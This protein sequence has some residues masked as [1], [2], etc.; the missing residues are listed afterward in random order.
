M[1]RIITKIDRIDRPRGRIRTAA[2][3]RVSSD[4]D[5][6]LV[7]LGN[8]RI[9]YETIIS[10]NPAWEFAGIYY[11]EGLSGTSK[12]AR[13][14]LMR[15]VSDCLAGR[16][17]QVITK[18]IS[19]FARNT[20]DCLELVRLLTAHGVEIFFEKEN[21]GTQNAGGELILS[22]LASIAEE[23]SRSISDNEK[24]A[25]QKRFLAGTFRLSR[26][27]YGY[28]LLDG[29]IRINPAEAETVRFIFGSILEGHGTS[30]IAS[31]LN[32]RG[33]P[34]KRGGRWHAGT[35][36]SMVHNVFF[37]GDLLM[38]KT[39]RDSRY[40]VQFNY[41]EFDQ[42]YIEGHHEPIVPREVFT[43]ANLA[44]NQRGREKNNIP[45]E[46]RS[47]RSDPHHRRYCF[48]GRLVCGQCS[49]TLKRRM[50][51]RSDGSHA[52]WVCRTHLQSA[53]ACASGRVL[54]VDIRNAFVTMLNKL[55]FARKVLLVPYLER[56]DGAGGC[57]GSNGG[58]GKAGLRGDGVVL[59][60]DGAGGTG[61]HDSRGLHPAAPSPRTTAID[62]Q[63][64][65]I[66]YYSKGKIEPVL[67]YKRMAE[68]KRGIGM[69]EATNG[70]SV[71]GNSGVTSHEGEDSSS[72][73]FTTGAPSP[74][75]AESRTSIASEAKALNSF[76]L[77]WKIGEMSFRD[78]MFT[79]FVDKVSIDNR[80]QVTFCLKCGLAL[81]ERIG[82]SQASSDELPAA[83]SSL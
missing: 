31:D 79:R 56:L 23:E 37:A 54:E 61:T 17:D 70:T 6:Q 73:S 11:D 62:E 82:A 60:S 29:E 1:K 83:R 68:L 27:P 78:D 3:C 19:R 47:M 25:I 34:T 49:D 28:D 7:S 36:Q 44:C 65:L 77:G 10:A 16:I 81:S 55:A 42:Y 33:I 50:I 14:E 39:W 20:M 57:A 46:D 80:H 43:A 41:G 32:A 69:N 9:H 52:I 58:A 63:K 22:I 5:A 26:A 67:F 53:G 64:R 40:R 35:I 13:P 71:T 24:W 15:L 76:L 2:Y 4:R 72:P 74:F 8:Q 21:L 51:Y 30:W 12:E 45:N 59:C 75:A 66:M 18:S 48:T 38:Q